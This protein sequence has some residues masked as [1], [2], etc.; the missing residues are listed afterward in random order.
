MTVKKDKPVNKVKEKRQAYTA[1]PVKTNGLAKTIEDLRKS[2]SELAN[3]VKLLEERL[4]KVESA[5]PGAKT[6]AC[7]EISREDAEK[8]IMNLFSEGETL[9]YSDIAEKLDL[10]LPAVVDIC[11]DL[12][13]RGEIKVNDDS[14]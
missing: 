5:L 10:E 6:T 13:K 2:N 1:A 14:L 11:G 12:L 8:E 9:Y 3:R 7:R 4:A